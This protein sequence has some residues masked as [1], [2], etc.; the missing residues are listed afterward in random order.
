MLEKDGRS[1]YLGPTAG[2]E[3]LKDA[4]HTLRPGEEEEAKISQSEM[5]DASAASP[6]P[7]SPSP[8]RSQA[9]NSLQ[10]GQTTTAAAPTAFPFTVSAKNIRT[11]ELL[12][13]LPPKEEAWILVE[14][15]YRYC[16]WQ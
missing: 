1:Q 5:Q 3:W 15:Y 9:P 8:E 10:S 16:A 6:E 14:A 11:S 4:S 13:C 2:S 7:S 12:S